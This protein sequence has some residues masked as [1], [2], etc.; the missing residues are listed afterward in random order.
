MFLFAPAIPALPWILGA[1]GIG[2]IGAVASS[3][4]VD[5]NTLNA[6]VKD[7]K[8]KVKNFGT[9]WQNKIGAGIGNVSQRMSPRGY[10]GSERMGQKPVA[11]SDATRVSTPFV[12]TLLPGALTTTAGTVQL[13]KKRKMN[14]A[15][16]T[17]SS[18]APVQ[19]APAET[20]GTEAGSSTAAPNPNPQNDN[21][22]TKI[23]WYKKPWE[24]A[25]NSP[26]T[27]SW[28]RG[29][30]NLGVRVPI[31]TGVAAPV[32]DLAGNAI[33]ASREDDEVVHQFTFPLT[34]ARFGLE[35]GIYKL[36]GDQ[37][38]TKVSYDP[39]YQETD[40]SV[41]QEDSIPTWRPQVQSVDTIP[42]TNGLIFNNRK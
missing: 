38:A 31:Y 15:S 5:T 17:G 25:K 18:T 27:S 1:L 23:K 11:V 12:Q 26:G 33:G 22:S 42:V 29:F 14:T 24:T 28:G 36:I 34:R 37:Y 2:T 13:A 16:T 32:L 4:D 35:K 10:A 9:Y 19:P 40:A 21:D 7:A 30:R 6:T 3:G 20:T 8:N 39:S 41:T